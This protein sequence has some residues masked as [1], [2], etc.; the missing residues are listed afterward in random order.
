[1]TGDS[2]DKMSRSEDAV[3]V[4]EL[5]GTSSGARLADR[6]GEGREFKLG[7]APA[8][9]SPS[10]EP[11][12]LVGLASV[13]ILSRRVGCL[14]TIL[15]GGIECFLKCLELAWSVWSLASLEAL[16]YSVLP[17]E[18]GLSPSQTTIET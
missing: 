17:D 14:L 6:E 7:A 3:T 18:T 13:N 11:G 4:R 2:G 12:L 8:P 15:N 5:T 9:S 1:M 10:S 16:L